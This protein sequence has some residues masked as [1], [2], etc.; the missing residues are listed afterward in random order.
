MD[1][2]IE[3]ANAIYIKELRKTKSN[4]NTPNTLLFITTYKSE[5]TDVY[6]IIHQNIPLLK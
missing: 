5:N 3:R 2:G 6:N 1:S 4:T